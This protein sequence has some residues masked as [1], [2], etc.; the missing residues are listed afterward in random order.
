MQEPRRVFW[1]WTGLVAERA[2]LGDVEH[3]VVLAC[4]TPREES[5]S[6]ASERVSDPARRREARQERRRAR[7]RARGGRSA[8]ASSSQHNNHATA[9]KRASLCRWRCFGCARSLGAT[10]G[11]VG[12]G[13]GVGQG[14]DGPLGMKA[15]P[16]RIVLGQADIRPLS[17]CRSP[18][19][20]L[21]FSYRVDRVTRHCP[22]ALR[23]RAAKSGTRILLWTG[24]RLCA[25][26]SATP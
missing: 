14:S 6:R 22:V 10:P 8:H 26:A 18:Q 3:G 1:A 21:K 17:S 12:A 20:A 15:R 7:G 23:V 9:T 2:H 11:A 16:A 24:R 4:H 5:Q 13:P 25:G 19:S